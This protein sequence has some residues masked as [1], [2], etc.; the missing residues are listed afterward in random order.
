M[1]VIDARHLPSLEAILAEK[2]RRRQAELLHIESRSI[3]ETQK[4][5]I[6]LVSFM[7]LAWPILHP[8]VP[9]KHNWHLELICEHLEA[10]TFGRFKEF[11]FDNRLLINEPPGTMKSLLV[12]VFWTAWEWG[13]ARLPH[14][15]SIA[16]SYKE[17]NCTR[18]CEKLGY[19]LQSE[20]F[21]K[22]WPLELVRVSGHYI[23]NSKRGEYRAIPFGSL[24]QFRADRV[25]IDD[26]H[27]VDTAESDADRARATIRFRESV[28]TRVN[29]P[30]TSAII[31]IMQRLHMDDIS[32][33]AIRLEL[34]YMHLYLPM[35]FEPDN[36]CVTPFGEDIRTY[37]GELLFPDRF[38]RAVVDRDKKTLGSYAIA[39]QFQQHPA[40]REGGMFKKHWFKIIKAAP[41]EIRKHQVRKW[42]LAASLPTAGTNPDY[43]VGLRMGE[44]EGNYYIDDVVRF[45]ESAQRVRTAIKTLAQ[46]DGESCHILVPQDPGQAGKDQ[47]QSII[48]ENAG[49]R[50]YADPETKDKAT[51][52]EPFAAQLEAGNIYLVEAPWNEKFI[53]ELCNF[54]TGHDDQVDGASGAFNYLIKKTPLVV[55]E[56]LLEALRRTVPKR[57][58]PPTRRY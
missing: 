36:R 44:H 15:Q 9:Y 54:P 27:S 45:Q 38:P 29:D 13:P 34:G 6:K 57:N 50:I 32:G 12:N 31:I 40:P 4:A 52:A 24:T 22:H 35:E 14:M 53:D 43:T 55:T 51:R 3:A 37:S 28:P 23:Q 16:T 20:W 49:Y 8:T 11:G 1:P 17:T 48:R 19:I 21:Q 18:D 58:W 26:P 2:A 41:A 7:R 42:D 56:E 47:V 46:H 39:G 30:I 10:I 33:I 5:C 25:K